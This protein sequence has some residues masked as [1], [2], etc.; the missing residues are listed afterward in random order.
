MM[1]AEL[2]G[3]FSGWFTPGGP[4]STN[5]PSHPRLDNGTGTIVMGAGRQQVS[6]RSMIH[7]QLL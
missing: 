1:A 7:A 4:I 3:K 6:A 2:V 5:G